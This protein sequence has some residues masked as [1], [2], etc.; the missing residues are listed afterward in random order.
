MEK[1]KLSFLKAIIKNGYAKDISTVA[2][3][4][5]FRQDKQLEQIGY[6]MGVNGKNGALLKDRKT[7][8]LYAIASR[9]SNLDYFT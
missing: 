5:A 2:N 3:V 4:E 8:A 1:L 6:S 9:C 7:G